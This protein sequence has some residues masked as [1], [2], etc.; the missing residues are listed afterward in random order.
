MDS[1]ACEQIALPVLQQCCPLINN[2]A[3]VQSDGSRGHRGTNRPA[4]E[5]WRE[6]RSLFT[7]LEEMKKLQNEEQGQQ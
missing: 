6:T 3:P 1:D 5:S 2:G 7:A 4:T